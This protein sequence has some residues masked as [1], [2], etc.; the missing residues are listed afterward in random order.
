MV[1][2]KFEI[3][4]ECIVNQHTRDTFVRTTSCSRWIHLCGISCV[5]VG[6]IVPVSVR[7]VTVSVSVIFD[8]VTVTAS[9]SVSVKLTSSVVGGVEGAK[10]LRRIVK[11]GTNVSD[12]R[13]LC[14]QP[15]SLV[16]CSG[17]L[18]MRLDSSTL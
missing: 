13:L 17:L 2:I 14:R 5:G 6:V 9:V 15:L 16:E 3:G 7:I 8:C 12:C 10:K 18:A 11:S 4:D 1:S